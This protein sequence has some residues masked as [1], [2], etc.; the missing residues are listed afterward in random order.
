MKT[1]PAARRTW[2]LRF[3]ITCLAIAVLASFNLWAGGYCCRN[4]A[5]T[6]MQPG[7]TQQI[8][9]GSV[10]GSEVFFTF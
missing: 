3:S 2:N 1:N 8:W 5:K 4:F 7:A 6:S 9:N 10:T